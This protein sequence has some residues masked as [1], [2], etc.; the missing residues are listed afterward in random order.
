MT[1]LDKFFDERQDTC[2]HDK[3]IEKAHRLL[4]FAQ[5]A[6]APLAKLYAADV[7]DG[8]KVERV[9]NNWLRELEGEK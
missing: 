2:G 9:I 1:W 8:G 3:D 5:D 6:L 7:N 4:V